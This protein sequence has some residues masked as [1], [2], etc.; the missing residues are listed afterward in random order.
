MEST[1]RSEISVMADQDRA[2][3]GLRYPPATS[4]LP[5]RDNCRL[6]EH[7]QI[8][9]SNSM[10]RPR[11]RACASR[12]KIPRKGAPLLDFR[13]T[14]AASIRARARAP[15]GTIASI[16]PPPPHGFRPAALDRVRR[17]SAA[18][19]RCVRNRPRAPCRSVFAGRGSFLRHRPTRQACSVRV[20]AGFGFVFS[21]DQLQ[22]VV[23]PGRCGQ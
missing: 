15:I 8:G 2:A 11:L 9:A 14:Q 22:N 19:I 7:H 16:H 17:S 6:V 13:K 10:S 1:A 12:R 23:L 5:D 20:F 21:E 3:I 4:R 18:I